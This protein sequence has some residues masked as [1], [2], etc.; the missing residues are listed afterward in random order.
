MVTLMLCANTSGCCGIPLTLCGFFQRAARFALL[1]ILAAGAPG[2]LASAQSV[3]PE[4]RLKAAY[5]VQLPNFVHGSP[6]QTPGA[7]GSGRLCVVGTFDFGI[8]LAQAASSARANG[9]SM[10]IRMVQKEQDIK[11]CQ[12]L[13]ISHSEHNR[14]AKLLEA[15]RA[16]HVLTVGETSGFIE[17]GGMIELDYA[18]SSVTLSVNL[19]AIRNGGLR[20]DPRLLG[21]AK[22]VLLERQALGS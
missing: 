17:A 4:H 15:A 13:F 16:A 20:L 9:H 1:C 3:D 11:S 22:R 12:I 2:F 6:M 5:L 14:Y 7:P 10:E 18:N 8:S 21:L 19:D